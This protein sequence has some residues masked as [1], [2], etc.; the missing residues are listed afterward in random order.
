M[1]QTPRPFAIWNTGIAAMKPDHTDYYTLDVTALNRANIPLGLC[2]GIVK[3]AKEKMLP[4][5]DV[6]EFFL[7][8]LETAIEQGNIDYVVEKVEGRL[9]DE[10]LVHKNIL[11]NWPELDY[12]PIPDGVSDYLKDLEPT[13]QPPI[14]DS[15]SRSTMLMLAMAVKGWGYYDCKHVKKGQADAE[16]RFQKLIKDY[17]LTGQYLS[18]ST[19]K[20]NLKN[21]MD[22]L[23]E[24][25]TI[26][27]KQDDK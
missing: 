1:I 4:R 6:A 13:T 26:K 25:S 27:E 14:N 21:A 12:P 3:Q 11:N 5:C 24:F 19:M 17:G 18:P 15:P 8:Q 22:L 23:D 7:L 2:D 9:T 16:R 10:Y 20:Y